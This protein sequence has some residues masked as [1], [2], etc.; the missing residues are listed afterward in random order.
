[1]SKLQQTRT[2]QLS[3]LQGLLLVSYQIKLTMF[4]HLRRINQLF[5]DRPLVK[6]YESSFRLGLPNKYNVA[7]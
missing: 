4:V 5:Q 1:M 7:L 3:P 2:V 6:G